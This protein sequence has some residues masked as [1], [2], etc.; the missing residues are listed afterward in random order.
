[1]KSLQPIFSTITLL[2]FLYSQTALADS[3]FYLGWEAG[4]NR[5][6]IDG[7]FT[8]TGRPVEA[9]VF[10][11]AVAGGYR[12]P[13][14]FVIEGGISAGTGDFLFGAFDDYSTS[15]YEL[16]LGYQLNITEGFTI[17]PKFGISDWDLTAREGRF[18]N[19]GPE[20]QVS[21]GG[22]DAIAQLDIGLELGNGLIL[23]LSHERYKAEYGEY[24]SSRFSMKWQF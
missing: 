10:S 12:W 24:Q 1:M 14:N 11:A 2:L 18:L 23:S 22:Q 19:P 3:G 13:N 5:I 8:F 7:E 15:K 21:F 4:T 6:E 17:V 20:D 9:D 16:L